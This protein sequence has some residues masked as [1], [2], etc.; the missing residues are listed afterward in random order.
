[1]GSGVLIRFYEGCIRVISRSSSDRT[2]PKP[3]GVFA[4]STGIATSD[5]SATSDWCRA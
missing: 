5:T 4:R 1:M 2:L 3:L